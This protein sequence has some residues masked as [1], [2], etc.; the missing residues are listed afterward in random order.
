[1]IGGGVD[2]DSGP[3][4]VII[5][6]KE[7]TGFFNVSITNDSLLEESELFNL[8]INSSS[9]PSRV[10]TDVNKVNVTITDNDGTYVIFSCGHIL[11]FD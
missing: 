2:Y 11:R 3:Y 10:T 1:M 8:V 5:S 4:T 7:E 9:L 6:A